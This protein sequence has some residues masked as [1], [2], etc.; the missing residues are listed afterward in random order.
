[1]GRK[2]GHWRTLGGAGRT[3]RTGRSRKLVKITH[4][5]TT[6][7][8]VSHRS[9]HGHV[10]HDRRL[11]FVGALDDEHVADPDALL[12]KDHKLIVK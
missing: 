10:D 11:S 7:T 3:G 1:M 6:T 8:Q 5:P 12:V 2:A 9:R 4:I